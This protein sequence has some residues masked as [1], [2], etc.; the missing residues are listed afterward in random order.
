MFYAV[1]IGTQQLALPDFLHDDWL[2]DALPQH[3]GHFCDLC[4][5]VLVMEFQAC[6]MLEPTF[7]ATSLRLE[8]CKPLL[9]FTSV[10]RSA[11]LGVLATLLSIVGSPFSHVLAN[12]FLVLG[13]PFFGRHC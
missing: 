8:V 5:A 9:A 11:L 6:R 12:F 2:G 13:R 7:A 1:T 4:V 10:R 3:D